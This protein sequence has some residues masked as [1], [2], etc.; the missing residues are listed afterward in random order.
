VQ[1]I[2][3]YH[4]MMHEHDQHNDETPSAFYYTPYLSTPIKVA[5]MTRHSQEEIQ[6]ALQVLETIGG[7]TY[8]YPQFDAQQLPTLG[9][10]FLQEIVD[11]KDYASPIDTEAFQFLWRV[12]TLGFKY[13]R[14]LQKTTPDKI[15]VA[16]PEKEHAYIAHHFA[17]REKLFPHVHE[18]FFAPKQ[19][20]T[21]KHEDH[22]LDA[23]D[24][25]YELFTQG[26]YTFTTLPEKVIEPLVWM[27]N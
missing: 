16:D 22:R 3:F 10:C 11:T 13:A 25:I 17:D 21:G 7:Y 20:L 23:D 4:D 2:L 5:I 19:L 9:Y 24:V 27:P 8:G 12:M 6:K 1:A 18:F 15:S 14:E 26:I